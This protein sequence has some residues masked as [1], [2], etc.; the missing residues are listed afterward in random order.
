MQNA[1]MWKKN[2]SSLDMADNLK[3]AFLGKFCQISTF[4]SGNQYER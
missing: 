2:G 4:R 3:V 1:K